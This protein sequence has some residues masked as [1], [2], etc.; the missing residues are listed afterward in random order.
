MLSTRDS[1]H[2]QGQI[3]NE[4]VGI[5]KGILCKQ[6]SRK[7]EEQYS[8]QTKI[9]FKI[10]SVTGDNFYFCFTDYAK[11]FDCV[12]HNKLWKIIKEMGIPDQFTCLLRNMHA[13]Q[14][15]KLEP[16]MEQ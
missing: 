4:S 5:E 8:C 9:D 2:I 11:A 13:G 1:L 3:Q 6:K 15:A 14:E 12:D 10:N 7:L 16:D